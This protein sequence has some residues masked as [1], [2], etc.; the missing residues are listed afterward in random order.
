MLYAHYCI[1]LIVHSMKYG[2]V[3]KVSVQSEHEEPGLQS[4]YFAMRYL[5]TVLEKNPSMLKTWPLVVN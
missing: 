5:N 4:L 3:H 1:K 2:A